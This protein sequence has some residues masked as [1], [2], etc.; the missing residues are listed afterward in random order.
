MLR[1]I[2][3]KNRRGPL[4]PNSIPVTMDV[5]AL[6]PSVP[7][8][9]GL[10]SLG[11]ALD[12]RTDKQ[13]PTSF[14]VRLMRLV[15]TMNTFVWDRKLLKQIMGTAIGTRAAPTFCGLFMGELEERMLQM[16]EDLNPD[17]LPGQWWR[18]LDD[19]QFWWSGTPGDLLIFINF[20]GKLTAKYS[21]LISA[22]LCCTT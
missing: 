20:V 1:K 19:C 5:C 8:E 7:Q 13:V 12:S 18:F 4:P 2:A 11:R 21:L 15:L 3:E 22:C 16:W 14:L 10:E 17:C 9:E 6:Y